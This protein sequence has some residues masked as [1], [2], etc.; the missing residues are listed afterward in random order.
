M[1]GH[2]KKESPT[3]SPHSADAGD[4]LDYGMSVEVLEDTR[5][6]VILEIKDIKKENKKINGNVKQEEQKEKQFKKDL[7]YSQREIDSLCK[8][9]DVEHEKAKTHRSFVNKLEADYKLQVA[10]PLKQSRL[11]LGLSLIHI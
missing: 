1:V 10:L 5:R 3:E 2:G 6:A 9:I 4:I 8:G 11:P 7:G